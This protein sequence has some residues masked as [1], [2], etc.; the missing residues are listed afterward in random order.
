M[1]A[2]SWCY[3]SSQLTIP[4]IAAAL[5]LIGVCLL[6]EAEL[7][8]KTPGKAGALHGLQ[9]IEHI[10]RDGG[11]GPFL[12]ST[13]KCMCVYTFTLFGKLSKENGIEAV[14]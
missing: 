7:C 5:S 1:K 14:S 6:A 10:G 13:D 11:M 2:A 3:F 9:R 4:E 8:C 12:T